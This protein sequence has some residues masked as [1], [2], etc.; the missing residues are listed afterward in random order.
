MVDPQRRAV[1][2]DTDACPEMAEAAATETVRAAYISQCPT[3]ASQADKGPSQES[4]SD[5]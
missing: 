4:E 1:F 2:L 5:W 3:S